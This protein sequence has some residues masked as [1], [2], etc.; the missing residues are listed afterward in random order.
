M[1][2]RFIISDMHVQNKKYWNYVSISRTAQ[3]F[4][5]FRSSSVWTCLHHM[6]IL[7]T[8]NRITDLLMILA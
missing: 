3:K 6:V 8:Q 2:M 4:K 1:S 5:N 7:R